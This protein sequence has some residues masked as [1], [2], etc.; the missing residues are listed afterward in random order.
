MKCWRWTLWAM[1][2]TSD[3]RISKIIFGTWW[4]AACV[5]LETVLCGGRS[6]EEWLLLYRRA[7]GLWPSLKSSQQLHVMEL[8][9]PTDCPHGLL[10]SDV[11]QGP[12][13]PHA[14][15]PFKT[16]K[17]QDSAFPFLGASD[18]NSRVN[19]QE[20]LLCFPAVQEFWCWTTQTSAAARASF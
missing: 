10:G 3:R 20:G 11:A 9:T 15:N 7:S 19:C 5:G 13:H 12:P 4:H 6:V 2:V 17:G 1:S 18:V 16:S 8:P 14:Q